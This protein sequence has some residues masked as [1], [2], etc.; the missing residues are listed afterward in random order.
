MKTVMFLWGIQLCPNSGLG[1]YIYILDNLSRI[2][3]P[4]QVGLYRDDGLIIVPNSNGLLT[5]RLHKKII[6]VNADFF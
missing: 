3:N 5:S 6:K 1:G 4:N 2:I